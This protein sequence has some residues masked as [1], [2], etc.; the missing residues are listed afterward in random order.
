MTD[1]YVAIGRRP[2]AEWDDDPRLEDVSSR[3]VIVE[4]DAPVATGLV[5]ASGLPLYRVRQ[6]IAIGF[7]K[8]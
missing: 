5:D 4:D 1:R 2:R 8:A 7:V 3:Q 6:R